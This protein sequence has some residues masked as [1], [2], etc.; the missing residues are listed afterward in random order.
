MNQGKNESRVGTRYGEFFKDNNDL[1]QTLEF[2][3]QAK[4]RTIKNRSI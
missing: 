4:R 1:V 3:G 2:E